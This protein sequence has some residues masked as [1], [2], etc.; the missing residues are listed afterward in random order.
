MD[1]DE[2]D[3]K[4]A[5]EYADLR[6]YEPADMAL[7]KYMLKRAADLPEG[8]RIE[9][10]EYVIGGKTGDELD[11]AI[12]EFLESLYAN[13]KVTNKEERMKMFGM[14]LDDLLA[15]NDP[16]IDLA[17]KSEEE[18]QAMEER[19]KIFAGRI[20]KLRPQLMRMRME[21]KGSMMYPDANGTMRISAG[22]VKGYS[23][24]DAIHYDP[25]TTLTGVVE[26]YTG[27]DPFNAPQALLDLH[28]AKD[29][30]SYADAGL[31]DVPVCFLTTNDGTGGNSGSPIMNGK[32]ELIGLL[33][34]GNYESISADYHII[35]KLNRSINVDSRYVLFV[36]DKFADA[37]ELLREL[38]IR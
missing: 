9:A 36:L 14:K 28:A 24:G 1:R 13:T 11:A 37:K 3:I 16:L 6:Y 34:D 35:P 4:Q 31:G 33:F 17:D 20:Q 2:P 22:T 19:D 10:F 29:F 8:Q 30:G 26:K 18:R 32:G 25:F 7:F 38:K 27:E 21:Y 23:P 12:D 5:L 15:L